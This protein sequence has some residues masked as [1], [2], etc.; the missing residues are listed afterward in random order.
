LVANVCNALHI[1]ADVCGSL[2][3]QPDS[4]GNQIAHNR[5]LDNGTSPDP[6]DPLP[7]ADLAWDLTGADNCWA[8]NRFDTTFPTS[9][10]TC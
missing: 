8:R 2:G 9:L 10:P 1:P 6:I 4:D 3:I 7:G 5:L